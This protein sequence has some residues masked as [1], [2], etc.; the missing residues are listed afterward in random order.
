WVLANILNKLEPEPD[1]HGFV[2]RRSILTNAQPHVGRAV[3]VNLDLSGFFPTLT[4]RRIKGL[5][6]KL[7][8][9]EHVATVFALL[10]TEPPRARAE[11]DGKVWGV[12]LGERVLPQGAC[13]SP[14]LTNAICRRFDRRLAGLAARHTFEYTR[15]ADDL[16]FSGDDRR[17]VGLLLK[18][19]RAILADEGFTEH[20]TKTRVMGRGRRQEVTGVTVNHKLSLGREERRRLRAILH[21]AARHGLASQNRDQHPD[22]AAHLRGLV[23]HACMLEPERA[24]EWKAA[25]AHALG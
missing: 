6:T 13:T 22:F 24:A 19:A 4:F 5:F 23:S 15:Y 1:A 11:L 12:A 17:K 7:G 14:A 18:S 10:T 25:L 2:R 16:T 9:S 20:P 8:Y 3:V 21:N